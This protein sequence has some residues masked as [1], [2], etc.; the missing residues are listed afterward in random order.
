MK[1]ATRTR[2][3]IA[4]LL[5]IVIGI[6][7]RAWSVAHQAR[8]SYVPAPPFTSR[9]SLATLTENGVQVDLALEQDGNGTAVLAGTYT[10]LDAHVHVYSK[11]LPRNGINGAGRPTLLELPVQ[12]QI[13]SIGLLTASQPVILDR[14]ATLNTAF[15]VYPDGPVTLRLPI[16]LAA[17]GEPASITVQITY[18]ACSSTGFCLPPVENKPLTLALPR[19]P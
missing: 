2:L 9:Q 17:S 15:P 6:A 11:D 7:A 1:A 19:A 14:F 12:P 13:Q 4:V 8:A 3:I 16:A 10:P 18:M 5:S